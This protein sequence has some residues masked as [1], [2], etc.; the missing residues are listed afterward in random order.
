MHEDFLHHLWKYQKYNS[1]SE[2]KTNQGESLSIIEI[3]RHNQEN[4][5]PDFFNAKVKIDGQV[6]AGNIE[7]HVKSSDWYA[8]NHQEDSAY[9]NV[10]L[11]VVW[12]DD[13]EVFRRDNEIIPSFSLE[14]YVAHGTLEN[15]KSLIGIPSKHINCEKHFSS[16]DDFTISNWLERMYIERLEHKSNLIVDLLNESQ[17]NWEDILFKLLCKNFGLNKNGEVFLSLAN[18]IPFKVIHKHHHSIKEL[19]SLL[20]GVSGLL[21]IK[22]EEKYINDLKNE[23][24]Y[25]KHKYK[26]KESLLKPQFFRLRPD[27]FPSLRLAQLASVYHKKPN[28]FQDIINIDSTE[29]FYKLFNVKLH[30]FWDIHYSLSKISNSKVKRLSKSFIDLL[31]INTILPLKL[32]YQKQRSALD[33]ENLLNIIS[34]IK[35]EKN[36]KIDIFESIRPNTN[37]TALESQALLEL[38][39]NYCDKNYCLKCNLGKKLVNSSL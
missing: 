30:G 9:D 12:E 36:S 4:S 7:I 33:F 11:H 27:N 32:C 29:G 20:L 38:K 35:A 17:N 37:K 1:D 34:G 5:G 22:S 15:Y 24:E 21:N 23:Y 26:L 16:F 25:L 14:K 10:I 19:E 39:T 28:L 13:V 18:Q 2:L 3:G 31:I 8:H 6:W